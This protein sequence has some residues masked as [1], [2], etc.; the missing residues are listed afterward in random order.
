[1]TDT[2]EN[3]EL[4]VSALAAAIKCAAVK[5]PVRFYLNGVYLDFPRGRIVATDGTQ[6]FCGR[7]ERADCRAVIV[8]R[9]TV[10]DALKAA[11][12]TRGLPMFYVNVTADPN[13]GNTRRV[14]LVTAGAKLGSAE[15]DGQYPEYE[16]V[17]PRKTSGKVSQFDPRRVLKCG[18]ALAI[19]SGGDPKMCFPHIA[20]NGDKGAIVT[21]S[22]D[23]A[24]C[25]LLPVRAAAAQSIAWLDEIPTAGRVTE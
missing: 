18:E 3:Y 22:S 20:H 10:S 2:I 16:R 21:G 8:D 14:E 6:M 9:E 24:F 23:T 13:G 1:M 4:P 17:I 15:I 19:Y 25:V 7:I 12:S 5:D 11:K